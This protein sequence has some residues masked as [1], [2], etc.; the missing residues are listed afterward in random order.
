MLH[1]LFYFQKTKVVCGVLPV[2]LSV[3]DKKVR[4]A[5]KKVLNDV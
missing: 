1:L 2:A 4:M 5:L 3:I